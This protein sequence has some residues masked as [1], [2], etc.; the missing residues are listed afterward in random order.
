[1]E[2]PL[3]SIIVLVYNAEP[4]LDNCLDSIAAQT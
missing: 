4:Y 3:I 1:M 2:Q